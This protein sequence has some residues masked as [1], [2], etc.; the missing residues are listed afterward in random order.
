[1]HSGKRGLVAPQNTFLENIVRRSSGKF[2]F[3]SR[4]KIKKTLV[5]TDLTQLKKK[6]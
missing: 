4:D 1:M 2:G 5:E 6:D 3:E